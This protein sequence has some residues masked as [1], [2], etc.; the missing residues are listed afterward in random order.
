V[1]WAPGAPVGAPVVLV[2]AWLSRR[3][4]VEHV[5]WWPAVSAGAAAGALVWPVAYLLL[6]LRLAVAPALL[7]ALLD[8]AWS[9]ASRFHPPL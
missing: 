2:A 1:F 7:A 3:P 8:A 5:P 6:P 4:L 9:L